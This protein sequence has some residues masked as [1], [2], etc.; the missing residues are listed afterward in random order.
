MTTRLTR[1]LVAGVGLVLATALGGCGS[2]SADDGDSGGGS[3]CGISDL[4]TVEEGSLK[5]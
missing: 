1:T 4:Q 5:V 3:T 2:D